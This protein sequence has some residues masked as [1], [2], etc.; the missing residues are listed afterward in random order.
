[1]RYLFIVIS[2]LFFAPLSFSQD[3]ENFTRENS[4]L[5]SDQVRSVCIDKYGVKWFGT[6]SGLTSFNGSQWHS[7][8][9]EGNLAGNPINEIVFEESDWDDELWLATEN[10][11]FVIGIMV[12]SISAAESFTTDNSGLVS[13]PA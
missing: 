3:W 7:Y 6:D 8:T 2:I 13:T 9:G 12:D 11:V 5:V 10:G 1:M 4:P